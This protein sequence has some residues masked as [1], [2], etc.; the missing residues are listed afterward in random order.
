[1]STPNLKLE[2]ESE[3][4]LFNL[5]VFN[6]NFTKI[7]AFS[8]EI[9]NTV[10]TL[11]TN[12]NNK[13][14]QIKTELK[15]NIDSDKSELQSD[16][17]T[18]TVKGNYQGTSENL[19]SMIDEIVATGTVSATGGN[20]VEFLKKD[21]GVNTIAGRAYGAQKSLGTGL[22]VGSVKIDFPT[23]KL[24]NRFAFRLRIT[25]DQKTEEKVAPFVEYLIS[26]FSD[27]TGFGNSFKS[28]NVI[29][30]SNSNDVVK[31]AFCTGVEKDYLL[32]GDL[33]TKWN[34]ATIEI[35]D[36]ETHGVDVNWTKD[37]NISLVTEA[38]QLDL[39]KKVIVNSGLNA[40]FFNGKD[41]KAMDKEMIKWVMIFA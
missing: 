6:D 31:V 13:M 16:I 17:N 12:S 14:E 32:I 27:S 18:R 4:E 28:Q 1:M 35:L 30:F 37:W 8:V 11:E 10:A 20:Y 15:S 41:K 26:G 38:E 40:T 23:S 24:N 5:D 29:P 9:E 21:N 33:T 19:K 2:I 3:E 25:S 36:I 34:N 39:T 22:Q 7:E